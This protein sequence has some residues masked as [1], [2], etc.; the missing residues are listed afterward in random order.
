MTD[1]EVWRTHY[2]D[3][4]RAWQDR[5]EQNRAEIEAMY[6]ARFIR[7]WRYYLIA[8]EIG[9]THLENVIFHFQLAR[10]QLAVPRTRDYMT[11]P[12]D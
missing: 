8:S 11:A 9:F 2:V 1:I 4:L 3:T 12:D 10:R 6:D 5:F 7:M